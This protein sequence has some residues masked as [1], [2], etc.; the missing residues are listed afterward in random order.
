M[1]NFFAGL[2][3]FKDAWITPKDKP[4]FLQDIPTGSLR[5]TTPDGK[6]SVSMDIVTRADERRAQALAALLLGGERIMLEDADG[7][8]LT[9]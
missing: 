9:E 7:F 5:I 2:K 3:A 1:N 6:T 4:E 8:G